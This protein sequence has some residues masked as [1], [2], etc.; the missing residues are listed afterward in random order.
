V[1]YSDAVLGRSITTELRDRAA[2]PLLTIGKDRFTRADL[3]TLTC[4][5]FIAAATLSR[6]IAELEVKDTKDLFSRIPPA[7]FAVP[8]IGA[9]ALFVL[10]AAFEAK[11]FGGKGQSPLE[12]WVLHHAQEGAKRPLVTFHTIKERDAAARKKEKADARRRR[13]SSSS[14]PAGEGATA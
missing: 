7:S 14:T 10:G 11:G 8:G 5:N 13:R 4:F 9:I 12:A 1:I 2:A 6:Y 3:S